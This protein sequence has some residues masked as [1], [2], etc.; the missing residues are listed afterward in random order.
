MHRRIIKVFLGSP[1]DLGPEREA[2]F[3][4]VQ[5]INQSSA[6]FWKCQ[7]DLVGW[8]YTVSRY[9]RAQAIINQEL[10]QCEYFIGMIWQKWGSPPGGEGHPYTSGFEEEFRRS[11]ERR[12]REGQPEISLLFKTP[13]PSRTQDPGPELTKVTNF[14]REITDGKAILYQEFRDVGE[15]ES[16]F[17]SLLIEY[18]QGLILQSQQVEQVSEAGTEIKAEEV[19][20][21]PDHKESLL[22]DGKV[23]QFV[24]E[25]LARPNS[26]ETVSAADVAR[27]R[28]AANIVGVVGND[29]AEIGAHDANLL[30]AEKESFDFSER[31]VS[32]LI[33]TGLS[34]FN[35]AN[36]PLWHWIAASKHGVEGALAW[37]SLINTAET[38]A[39][40]I[41]CL[42]L[43]GCDLGRGVGKLSRNEI[44]DYWMANDPDSLSAKAAVKYLGSCGVRE[45][46][47]R[48]RPLFKN[49]DSNV[50]DGAINS[51]I[52]ISTRH[53]RDEALEIL[54]AEQPSAISPRLLQVMFTEPQSIKTATLTRAATHRAADVRR[55]AISILVEREA[56]TD[57]E[58]SDYLSDGDAEV[59]YIVLEYLQGRG[60][61]FSDKEAKAVL[62][63][64]K[65]PPTSGL[66]SFASGAVNEGRQQHERFSHSS[67]MRLSETELRSRILDASAHDFDLTIAL[68]DRYFKICE[69]EL[70]HAVSDRFSAEFNRRIVVQ[71]ERFGSMGAETVK[72]TEELSE[73]IR[74]GV[75][76][77][78]LSIICRKGGQ[79]GLAV[80][81]DTIDEGT[82]TFAREFTDYL[83]KYG[84]VED[85]PRIGALVERH[86]FRGLG[87][88]TFN[89]SDDY[90]Y[91]AKALLKL[92][93]KR[94]ADLLAMEFSTSLRSA[95]VSEM[96]SRQFSA[97]ADSAVIEFLNSE[98]ESIRKA[99]ALKV[100]LGLTKARVTKLLDRYINQQSYRY[101]NVIHWLDIA[102]S[103]PPVMAKRVAYGFLTK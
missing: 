77:Q 34:S 2:A 100:V 73:F 68:Y 51:A 66:L 102:V 40:A 78:A 49:S 11:V 79:N 36:A 26:S 25:L 9:G 97:L 29:K 35:N 96:S 91:A 84:S 18:V 39:N 50:S 14:K 75:V 62:L 20:R 8:E 3:K 89:A 58:A 6:D 60:R 53:D 101:Y 85:G 28:L 38:K 63:R 33:T 44:I 65:N 93:S 30:Y 83:C 71:R 41:T 76:Q 22:L 48:L 15:F 32:T 57:E 99:A 94:V 45:D 52:E 12:E 1:G 46:I 88:L 21:S 80:V 95:I 67:L 61:L 81:R 56:L 59:R 27:F 4:V 42:A 31:E 72:K 86:N 16:K 82:V 98:N 47:G 64:A 17:R 74:S 5:E 7:I 54:L 69:S 103:L 19:D 37:Q 24:Q 13:E 87:I 92:Y 90:I 55:R 43:A 70:L 10:E 23:R